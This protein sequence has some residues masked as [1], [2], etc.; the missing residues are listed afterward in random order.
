MS[1]WSHYTDTS[2]TIDGNG[3]QNMVTT[4]EYLL[5]REAA[6]SARQEK[7]TLPVSSFFWQFLH[8]SNIIHNFP[9]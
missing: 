1:G 2:E 4:P 6:K 7:V 3:A 9:A 8:E 5:G